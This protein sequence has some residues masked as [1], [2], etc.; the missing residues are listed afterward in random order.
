MGM[1]HLGE[2]GLQVLIEL[3]TVPKVVLRGLKRSLTLM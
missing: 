1:L 2:P 3:E